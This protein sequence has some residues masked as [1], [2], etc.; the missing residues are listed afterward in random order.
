MLQDEA[1][2]TPHQCSARLLDSLWNGM[3]YY[4]TLGEAG[5]SNVSMS[6]LVIPNHTPRMTVKSVISGVILSSRICMQV[7]Q[8]F[9]LW[10]MCV[11]PYLTAVGEWMV[12]GVLQDRHHELC[13][14]RSGQ[15]TLILCTHRQL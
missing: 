10:V 5:T 9:P 11:R 6:L 4:D 14:V 2:P 15:N 12:Q 13:M 3:Q 7:A 8:L 1:T